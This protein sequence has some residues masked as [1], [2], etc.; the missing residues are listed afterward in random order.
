MPVRD[1]WQDHPTLL[2]WTWEATAAMLR[3]MKP[4]FEKMG[5]ETSSKIVKSPEE[6]DQARLL[7][8][9]QD[10]AQCLLHYNGM[11]CPMN[12]PKNLRNG[13]CGGVRLNGKCEVKPEMDC[14][15]VRASNASKRR[16]TINEMYRLNPPVDWRLEG[17]ASWVTYAIGRDQIP[18]GTDATIRYADEAARRRRVA[19]MERRQ[20]LPVAENAPHA[21]VQTGLTGAG[22]NLA[23]VLAPA[24]SRSASRFRRRSAP[25]SK[26]S[27]ARST[28]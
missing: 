15:W 4:I 22:S 21:I 11:T 24:S 8:N 14:V 2:V 27:S 9:C 7:F 25:T 5:M 12:C 3:W 28:R 10:C 26:P 20:H 13:P 23:K 1:L 17:Q 6:L 19:A 16:P 18:T